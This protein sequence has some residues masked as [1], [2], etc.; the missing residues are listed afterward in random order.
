[1]IEIDSSE[2]EELVRRVV[3]LLTFLSK[4]KLSDKE[5]RSIIDNTKFSESKKDTIYKVRAPI[6]S[7]ESVTNA[8]GAP[9]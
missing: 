6:N 9:N 7:N 2:E 1:M 4:F 5:Y 3:C 8:Q